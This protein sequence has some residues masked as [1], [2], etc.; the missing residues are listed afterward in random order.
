MLG[1]G[2]LETCSRRR[3][4]RSSA[5]LEAEARK[6]AKVRYL[7][8]GDVGPE[9]IDPGVWERLAIAVAPGPVMDADA[10]T[11]GRRPRTTR[12]SMRPA[13]P[14]CSSKPMT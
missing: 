1:A 9:P 8:S 11:P 6:H 3:A 10:R 14:R 2:P 4:P 7:L 13:S 12:S 5:T